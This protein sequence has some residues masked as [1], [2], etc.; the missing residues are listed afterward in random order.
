MAFDK[1]F[2][3]WV[4]GAVVASGVFIQSVN[5]SSS[6]VKGRVLAHAAGCISCHTD[7]EN[8][9]QLLAGGKRFKTP[10]GTF[11]APN[12]SP[13]KKHGIGNWSN[14]D[15]NRAMTKGVSPENSHYFPIFPYTSF[16]LM[17]ADDIKSIKEFIFSLPAIPKPSEAHKLLF[18][19]NFRSIQYLWKLLYFSQGPYKFDSKRTQ[20]WNRG[21]Y[22][23]RGVVHCHECHTR[24]TILGGLKI[25]FGFGGVFDN[26]SLGS[27]YTPNITSHPSIGIGS[28]SLQQLVNYLDA[29]E[30]PTGDFA[31][32]SMAEVIEKGTSKLSPEDRNAIAVFIKSIRPLP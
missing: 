17:D 13:D 16:T 1:Y 12:I 23:S 28:W 29:G 32:G 10:F 7:T 2:P 25:Q 26:T 9:G 8:N 15:F 27:S 19:F 4:L 5:V 24:R 20:T 18:P 22:L 31:G 11:V 30:D 21:A 3:G 6:V 14:R